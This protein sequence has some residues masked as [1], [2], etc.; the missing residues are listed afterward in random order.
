[1]MNK[2]RTGCAVGGFL[3]LLHAIWAI[4]VVANWAKPSMDF[5]FKLHMMQNPLV[6]NQFDLLL[7]VYLVLFTAVFG[8][9]VGWVFAF[10]HNW[11]HMGAKKKK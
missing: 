7:S 2:I 4:M 11:T 6:M 10:F 8:F 1:M 9:L 5:I 3:A